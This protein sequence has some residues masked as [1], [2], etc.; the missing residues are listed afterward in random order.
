MDEHSILTRTLSGLRSDAQPL[1]MVWI[2]A[3]VTHTSV[4]NLTLG[5]K[6]AE[7]FQYHLHHN[8]QNTGGYDIVNKPPAIEP[9][10]FAEGFEDKT[11]MLIRRAVDSEGV[12]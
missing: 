10:R 3:W 2:Q 7:P 9:Q 8:L 11:Q 1:A 5:V 4:N 12:K 6:I